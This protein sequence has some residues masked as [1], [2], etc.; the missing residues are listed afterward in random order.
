MAYLIV[1]WAPWSSLG[2]TPLMMANLTPVHQLS[3]GRVR[4]CS[5]FSQHLKEWVCF[6]LRT[7]SIQSSMSPLMVAL[8]RRGVKMF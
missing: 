6:N 2:L 8:F 7:A 5:H 4:V 1:L 3:Y